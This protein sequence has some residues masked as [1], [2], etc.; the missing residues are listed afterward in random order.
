[1]PANYEY[2][3]TELEYQKIQMKKQMQ[4]KNDPP[5]T[6]PAQEMGELIESDVE[7]NNGDFDD[8]SKLE[9]LVSAMQGKIQKGPQSTKEEEE[10]K[11]FER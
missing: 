11:H 9:L 10:N 4:S 8:D 6:E 7:L 1:M 5:E 2:K 3:Y